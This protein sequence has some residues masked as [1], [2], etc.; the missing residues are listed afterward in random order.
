MG[1]AHVLTFAAAG[2]RGF[3]DK[4]FMMSAARYD[5]EALNYA[6]KSLGLTAPTA[7]KKLEQL[8][9]L[10]ADDLL[11]N[12]HRSTDPL[13]AHIVAAMGSALE[14]SAAVEEHMKAR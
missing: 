2:F 10:I 8:E 9:I 3:R 6:D 11:R 7:R 12:L 4:D 14:P 1:K 13:V 5:I